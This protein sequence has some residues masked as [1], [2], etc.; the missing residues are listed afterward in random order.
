M[1]QVNSMLERIHKNTYIKW[2]SVQE[3]NCIILNT[4]ICINFVCSKIV[5]ED[6]RSLVQKLENR[7]TK[8]EGGSSAPAAQAP[9]PKKP[10]P[11]DD[12][13]DDDIDLF[14]SDDEV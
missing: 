13:D 14:G 6:M 7:V 5:V 10:A 1:D 3:S 11:A 8:L 2:W 12:D 9:V 4:C